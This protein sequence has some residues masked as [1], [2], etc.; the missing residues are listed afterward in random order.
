MKN[1][2]I[3]RSFARTLNR[4]KYYLQTEWV[5]LNCILLDNHTLRAYV[6]VRK[7]V[8][9]TMIS[10]RIEGIDTWHIQYLNIEKLDGGGLWLDWKTALL[11]SRKDPA[12]FP[13]IQYYLNL[14]I[15]NWKMFSF[16]KKLKEA[17]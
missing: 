8:N 5:G 1:Y 16:A 12:F 3:K 6:K 14:A 7:N 15:E 9:K 11:P 10:I 4:I 13:R 2:W 17:A